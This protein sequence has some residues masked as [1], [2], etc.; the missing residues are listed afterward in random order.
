MSYIVTTENKITLNEDDRVA[1]ILQNVSII[2][3][4]PKGTVPLDR[5]F[6]I[7]NTFLDK[8]LPVAR[9]L[10]ISEIREAIERYEPRARV[11]NISFEHS[12]NGRLIPKVEVEINE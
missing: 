4:T 1:S 12:E 11:L 8:P 10:A 9:V 7:S 6:G 3:S 5:E 2:V